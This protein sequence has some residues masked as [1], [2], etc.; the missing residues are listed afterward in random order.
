MEELKQFGVIPVDV[1]ALETVFS[2]YNFPQKKITTLEQ[3]GKLIRLKRGLYVVAPGVS[4][5]ILSEEL[6]ANHLYG[7]SYV[8]METALRYYGLIP[9]N[10][11]TVTSMTL[12]LTKY[13]ENSV[14]KFEYI[15]CAKNYYSIG[16]RQVTHEDYAFQLASPEKAL[17]DLI[18][19]TPKLR[20]RTV[21]SVRFFLEEDLRFDMD[22]FYNLDATIFEQ[23]SLVSKKKT[24]LQNLVKL[25]KK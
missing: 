4:G 2:S 3:T 15:H 19:Y 18:A 5:R 22:A 6:I 10:V 11:Y 12:K 24:D 14:G 20:L 21:K 8:S 17:C 7:A 9:E 23:C 16:I 13:Y 25:L 1:A